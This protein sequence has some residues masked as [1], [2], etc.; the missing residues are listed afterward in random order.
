MPSSSSLPPWMSLLE[1]REFLPYCCAS[2]YCATV[3]VSST[4]NIISCHLILNSCRYSVFFVGPF[5][6]QVSRVRVC[7]IAVPLIIVFSLSCTLCCS[8]DG[9]DKQLKH[10]WS[11]QDPVMLSFCGFSFFRARVWVFCWNCPLFCICLTDTFRTEC[12]LGNQIC[13]VGFWNCLHRSWWT[14]KL[15]LHPGV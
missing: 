6:A 15:L 13:L 14:L 10:C 9:P 12:F 1:N 4:F 3:H 11:D 5:A 2:C 8:S 7:E